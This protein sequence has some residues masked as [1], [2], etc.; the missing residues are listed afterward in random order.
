MRRY[1][2]ESWGEGGIGDFDI[3]NW[4]SMSDAIP[5]FHLSSELTSVT[6]V[7]MVQRFA[8]QTWEQLKRSFDV[9][10]AM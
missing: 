9:L 3:L 2:R 5:Y 6:S 8:E 4:A 7:G 10:S 1:W